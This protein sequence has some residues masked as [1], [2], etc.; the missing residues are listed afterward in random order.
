MKR[1]LLF[2]FFIPL[3]CS[4]QLDRIRVNMTEAEFIQSFPEAQRDLESEAYWTN[5]WDAIEGSSGNSLWRIMNDTVSEYSFRSLKMDGPSYR[6]TT[7]DSAKVHQLRVSA[8]K[9]EAGLEAKLGKPS[10]LRSKD[11]LSRPV[12]PHDNHDPAIQTAEFNEIY[13]AQWLFDDG[14]AIVIR[15]STQ[16]STGNMINAPAFPDTKKSESYEFDVTVTRRVPEGFWHFET[17]Q[18]ARTLF[19]KFPNA[20]PRYAEVPHIYVMDDKAVASYAGWRFVF[21]KAQLREMTYTCTDPQRGEKNETDIIYNADKFR[22]EQ[23]LAEGNKAFGNATLIKNEIKSVY[24]PSESA[25]SYRNTYLHA[26]WKTET[27]PVI[28]MF[29]EIGGGKNGPPRFSVTLN[30]VRI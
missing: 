12:N 13:F 2:V 30:Y 21:E 26:E 25:V 27:G 10:V 23:L 8:M 24:E 5:H 17:G 3:L 4:A 9:L 7:V 18:S 6:F 11:L 16:L 22:A 20:Q 14:R 15:V 28:L 19:S 29:E 1:L